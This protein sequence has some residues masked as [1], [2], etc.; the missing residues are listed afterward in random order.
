MQGGERRT[1]H[2]RRGRQAA[3][4]RQA[5]LDTDRHTGDVHAVGHRQCHGALQ[6][7]RPPGG[8]VGER[9]QRSVRRRTVDTRSH[10]EGRGGGEVDGDCHTLGDGKRQHPPELVVGVVTDQVHPARGEPACG[11]DG[12]AAHAALGPSWGSGASYPES[13]S[14]DG[15]RK[16]EI[17]KAIRAPRTNAPATAQSTRPLFT[18]PVLANPVP[19]V[20]GLRAG[21]SGRRS[22]R[23]RRQSRTRW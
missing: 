13:C 5:T 9:V 18:T 1:G 11:P 7:G 6:V 12:P 14:L 20:T 19:A 4:R 2:G 23:G 3:S 21:R 22:V 10:L 8:A 16:S 15:R 17:A